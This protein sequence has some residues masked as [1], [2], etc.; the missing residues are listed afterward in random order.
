MALGSTEGNS[1]QEVV[2][3]QGIPAERLGG[4]A[5][6]LGGPPDLRADTSGAGGLWGA[7]GGQGMGP[8]CSLSPP[9]LACPVCEDAG[10]QR[11]AVGSAE[12][13]ESTRGV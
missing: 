8:R 7:V 5:P 2:S 9:S 12:S 1:E 3:S 6:P 13:A 4:A 10:C 11:G